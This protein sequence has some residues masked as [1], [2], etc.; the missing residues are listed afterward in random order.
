[1]RITWRL[2][3][4][5]AVALVVAG[6]G[7]GAS[8]EGPPGTARGADAPREVPVAS[9]FV[10]ESA[11]TPPADTQVVVHGG[12]PR[13]VILRHG[14]PE[15]ATFADLRFDAAAFRAGDSVRVTIRPVPGIYGV[16]LETERPFAAGTAHVTFKYA[17]YF[18]APIDARRRYGSDAAFERTLAVARMGDGGMA[19]LLPS[20]RPGADALRADLPGP[21]RYFVAAPR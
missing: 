12:Q 9:L 14:P 13:V 18:S 21:G 11:G 2:V 4:A 7:G 3:A 20:T 1:M 16:D 10:L 6:C 8:R 5:S 19:T 15:N 17:R